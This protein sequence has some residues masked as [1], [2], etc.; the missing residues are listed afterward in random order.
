MAGGVGAQT[1]TKK[2]DKCGKRIHTAVCVY[3]HAP[4][5]DTTIACTR[6]G[7]GNLSFQGSAP[8]S[9]RRGGVNRWLKFRFW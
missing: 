8:G 1:P 7:R 5:L 9:F 3:V 6:Y 2:V 4:S